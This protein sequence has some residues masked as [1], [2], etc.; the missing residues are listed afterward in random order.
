MYYSIIT[1]L[2]CT[3]R[4]AVFRKKNGF[5]TTYSSIVFNSMYDVVTI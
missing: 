2:Y 3:F 1:L 5:R 4:R